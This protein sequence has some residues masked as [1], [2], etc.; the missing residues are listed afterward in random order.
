MVNGAGKWQRGRRKAPWDL[1]GLADPRDIAE[2]QKAWEVR[3]VWFSSPG[4]LEVALGNKC[5][6]PQAGHNSVHLT[7]STYLLSRLPSSPD[8]LPWEEKS[9][10]FPAA[11]WESRE[12]ASLC[13]LSLFRCPAADTG[14][15]GD[16]SVGK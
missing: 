15:F 2:D 6:S 1:Q 7:Y 12:E 3:G 5:S 14:L 8:V 10:V 4:S 11:S 13:L 9:F 16:A